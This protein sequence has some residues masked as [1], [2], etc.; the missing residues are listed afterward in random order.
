MRN[1]HFFGIY[2]KALQHCKNQLT[3]SITQETHTFRA[4]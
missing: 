3:F 1:H 2:S 4:I